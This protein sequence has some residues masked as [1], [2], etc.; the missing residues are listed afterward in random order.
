M[1]EIIR[2]DD[3]PKGANMLYQRKKQCQNCY[4]FQGDY[5]KVEKKANVPS[6]SLWSEPPKYH[7]HE[8]KWHEYQKQNNG[9]CHRYPPQLIMWAGYHS[10]SIDSELPTVN[11]HSFCGEWE[12]QTHDFFD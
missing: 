3:K 10:S 8:V 5:K 6:L 11:Q 1:I 9:T 4:F 2:L 7:R 12:E